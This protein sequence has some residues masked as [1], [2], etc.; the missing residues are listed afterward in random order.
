MRVIL[1]AMQNMGIAIK[2]LDN[3]KHKTIIMEVP[4]QIEEDVF[5]PEISNAVKALWIDEGVQQA[6]ERSREYQLNDSAR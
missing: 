1:E 2:N 6:F 5:P 3:E 4:A